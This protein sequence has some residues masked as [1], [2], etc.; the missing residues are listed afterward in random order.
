MSEDDL[1]LNHPTGFR[2]YRSYVGSSKKYD[3]MAAHQFNLLTSLG[4][5]ENH[6]LLDI[7]CGSLRGGRL[8]I[9]YLLPN[10][11]FGIEPEEWLLEEGI[12]KNLG[13]EILRIKKPKFSNEKEFKLRVF[14]QKFDYILAQSIFSHATQKQILTCLSEAKKVMTESSFFV[15]TFYLGDANNTKTEWEYPGP[16]TYTKDFMK[17]AATENKL[18]CK[19]LKY[20]HLNGQTWMVIT[21][22]ANIQKIPDL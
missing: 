18:E 9:T 17:N 3:I 5:R 22:S 21:N 10:K 19:F 1:G 2:H 8:F 14:N 13:Q 12:K 7:G 11:Y 6:T 15:G 16:V 4:L 20:E